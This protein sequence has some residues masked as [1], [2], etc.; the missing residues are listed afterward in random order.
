MKPSGRRHRLRHR[1]TQHA[2]LVSDLRASEA[3][4]HELTWFFGRAL[5]D[6]EPGSNFWPLVQR[7]LSGG[8]ERMRS[9]ED[10]ADAMHRARKIHDR[11][12]RLPPRDLWVLRTL[13][14]PAGRIPGI[15][16][17][18]CGW[19]APLVC[20]LP[21]VVSEYESAYRGRQTDVDSP[22]ERL[23]ERYVMFGMEEIDGPLAEAQAAAT[24]ALKAY[25]L[26]RGGGPSIA[27]QF[28]EED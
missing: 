26:V 24:R 17:D 15:I 1:Y 10:R 4:N 3:A 22:A 5:T 20:A 14:G 6:I 12:C 7:A 16:D 19:L 25:E 27:P 9:S 2:A 18:F 28:E 8:Y 11:L 13:Y 21:R 23:K